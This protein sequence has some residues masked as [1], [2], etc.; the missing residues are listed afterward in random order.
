VESVIFK[1]VHYEMMINVKGHKWMVHSTQFR[2]VGETVGLSL[3]PDDIHIMKKSK[4]DED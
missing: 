2:E 4:G 3:D 1:G